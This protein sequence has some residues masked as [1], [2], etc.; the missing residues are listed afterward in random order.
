[1]SDRIR[2]AML[3]QRY[4]PHIGGAERQLAALAPL[5]N[6]QGVDIHIITRRDRGLAQFEY[7]DCVPVH[8]LPIPG[9]KPLASLMYTLTALHLLHQSRPDIIHAHELLS[10]ATTAVVAKRWLG[11]P[12]VAK[13]LRGGALGDLAKL[14]HKPLGA[15][16]IASLRRHMDAFIAISREIAAE[17]EAF[18]ID[19]ARRIYIPN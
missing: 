2:V 7:I 1:M 5:L 18:G 11:T 6:K 12:I 8:R 4:Y 3:I 15:N 9:P 19:P 14:R 17:L 10:P 16:R 13:V